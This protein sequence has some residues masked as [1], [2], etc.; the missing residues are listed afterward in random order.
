MT[1]KAT[2]LVPRVLSQRTLGTRLESYHLI[3]IDLLNNEAH[4]TT[5]Q[6]DY[7]RNL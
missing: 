7:L 1:V 3:V 2:N 4:D 5:D 6:L